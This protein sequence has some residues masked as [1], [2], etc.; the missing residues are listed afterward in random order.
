M[1][2]NCS[3]YTWSY[4]VAYIRLHLEQLYNELKVKLRIMYILKYFC[5]VSNYVTMEQMHLV[6]FFIDIDHLQA[7]VK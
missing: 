6:Y 5:F 2:L 4:L 3:L 7:S 1:A